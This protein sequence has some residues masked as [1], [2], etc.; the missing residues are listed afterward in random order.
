MNFSSMLIIDKR[1]EKAPFKKSFS[2][3]EYDIF[4][5]EYDVLIA[6]D[7]PSFRLM[8]SATFKT[9]GFS[10]D[11]AEDGYDALRKFLTHRYRLIIRKST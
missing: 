11:T 2:K 8:V 6:D 9:A 10:I 3:M 7:E 1:V 4:K 5:T